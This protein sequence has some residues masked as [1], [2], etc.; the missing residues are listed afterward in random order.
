MSSRKRRNSIRP[1]TLDLSW[2][3]IDQGHDRWCPT[4]LL[5]AIHWQTMALVNPVTLRVLRRAEFQA[6]HSGCPVEDEA[7]WI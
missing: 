4:C 5:P 7:R 1:A 2:F 6:C 3:L